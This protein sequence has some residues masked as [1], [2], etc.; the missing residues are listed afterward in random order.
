MNIKKIF[1]ALICSTSALLFNISCS[2][3]DNSGIDFTFVFLSYSATESPMPTSVKFD[4]QGSDL[5]VYW[6]DGV[7]DNLNYHTFA[8]GCEN[9]YFVIGGNI[10]SIS[11]CDE[12]GNLLEQGNSY[13][14]GIIFSKSINTIPK[15]AFYDISVE[16]VIIPTSVATIGEEAFANFDFDIAFFCGALSKP[17][18]WDK[19]WNLNVKL[20]DLY[21]WGTTLYVEDAYLYALVN[22]GGYKTASALYYYSDETIIEAKIPEVVSNAGNEYKVTNISGWFSDFIK[23]RLVKVTIPNNV[24]MIGSGAFRSCHNLETVEIDAQKSQLKL[25]DASAFNDTNIKS[26]TIPKTVYYIETNS[27]DD[28]ANLKDVYLTEYTKASEIAYCY[29]GFYDDNEGL[30]FHYSHGLTK[31]DFYD[32][33]WPKEDDQH[34]WKEETTL[35]A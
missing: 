30:T 29:T 35:I 11:F 5:K 23:D 12:S 13:I 24:K 16:T 3:P 31:Q 34:I 22:R 7:E 2:H 9:N 4:Y 32:K 26:I 20:G 14:I 27:F 8:E 10:T 1:F 6:G 21:F 19:N 17:N 28:C 25:V 18:G 15:K 33:G